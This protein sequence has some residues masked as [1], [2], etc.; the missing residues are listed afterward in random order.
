M[1]ETKSKNFFVDKKNDTI[2]FTTRRNTTKCKN[3][4]IPYEKKWKLSKREILYKMS[5]R[6][7]QKS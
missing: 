1:F 2:M 6:K 7:L 5:M 4:H 3:F